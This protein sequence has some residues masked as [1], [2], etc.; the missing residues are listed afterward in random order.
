MPD[1]TKANENWAQGSIA[2]LLAQQH[3]VCWFL[4][5]LW[6]AGRTVTHPAG[7]LG[8]I[9]TNLV[10]VLTD[11]KA[12]QRDSFAHR[13]E[14]LVLLVTLVLSWLVSLLLSIPCT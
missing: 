9:V 13:H 1:Y 5:T 6:L 2:Q 11:R 3:C 14:R 10:K 12:A 7:S 4:Q 8:D